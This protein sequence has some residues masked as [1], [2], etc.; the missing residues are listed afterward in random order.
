MH[1]SSCDV[2]DDCNEADFSKLKMFTQCLTFQNT[3]SYILSVWGLVRI[4]EPYAVFYINKL[5]AQLSFD[6]DKRLHIYNHIPC[7]FVIM[8]KIF[9]SCSCL[10][11]KQY[12]TAYKTI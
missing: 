11:F 4:R 1:N 2:Y 12:V 7:V 9:E 6:P 3:L 5:P 10:Y 8:M